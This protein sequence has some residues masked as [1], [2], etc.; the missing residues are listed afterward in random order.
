MSPRRHSSSASA[1]TLHVPVAPTGPPLAALLVHV[2]GRVIVRGVVPSQDSSE[3]VENAA[4]NAVTMVMS[5]SFK[6]KDQV[7]ATTEAWRNGGLAVRVY[8]ARS[9]SPSRAESV[10]DQTALSTNEA[11][12]MGLVA[13][14][15]SL[16]VTLTRPNW[17]MASLSMS[18]FGHGVIQVDAPWIQAYAT[19]ELKA[20]GPAAIVA[21]ASTHV[22]ADVME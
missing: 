14:N 1:T 11:S 3:D 20:S 8:L 21:V 17:T 4:A 13:L 19:I 9:A 10:I 16:Y 15:N 6:L 18:S 22:Q 5:G 12:H 2:P 7:V